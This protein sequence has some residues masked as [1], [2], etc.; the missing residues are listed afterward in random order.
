VLSDREIVD[1]RVGGRWPMRKVEQSHESLGSAG[2]ICRTPRE[3][4][5]WL[6]VLISEQG[7]I[8][9]F[10]VHWTHEVTSVVGTI[11]LPIAGHEDFAVLLSRRLFEILL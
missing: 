10:F 4:V 7:T 1:V 11:T 6:H 8:A 3:W 5:D 9:T 2:I